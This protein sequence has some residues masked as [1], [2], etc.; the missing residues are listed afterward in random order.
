MGS[1]GS[2]QLTPDDWLCI[3]SCGFDES[4]SKQDNEDS[5]PLYGLYYDMKDVSHVRCHLIRMYNFIFDHRCCK[6]MN[7]QPYLVCLKV[8]IDV[9]QSPSGILCGNMEKI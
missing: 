4:K 1:Y 5:L 9:H 6:Q 2:L 7:K 8:S 3:A